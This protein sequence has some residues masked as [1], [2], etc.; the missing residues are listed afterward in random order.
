MKPTLFPRQQQTL[1]YLKQH[2]AT[3]GTAPTLKQIGQAVGLSSV[4]SVHQQLHNLEL[5]NL[6]KINPG[7]GRQIEVLDKSKPTQTT[8]TAQGLNIPITSW[9][10]HGQPLRAYGKT[11]NTISITPDLFPKHTLGFSVRVKAGRPEEGILTNDYFILQKRPQYKSGDIV[12]VTMDSG[13]TIL[14]TITYQTKRVKLDNLIKP[15]PSIYSLNPQI[16][17]QVIAMIRKY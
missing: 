10:E 4:A 9:F 13:S 8:T 2:I 6:I 12:L 1:D 16:E 3:H 14:K 17:G 7:K 15:A 11:P 5:R